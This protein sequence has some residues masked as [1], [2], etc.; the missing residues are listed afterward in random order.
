[1]TSLKMAYRGWTY[2]RTITK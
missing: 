2:S 1:M